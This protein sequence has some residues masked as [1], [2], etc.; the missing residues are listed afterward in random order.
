[1]QMIFIVASVGGA[2]LF[3]GFVIGVMVLIKTKCR[4]QIGKEIEEGTVYSILGLEI[5]LLKS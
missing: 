1:M 4:R 5:S 2:I 3:V